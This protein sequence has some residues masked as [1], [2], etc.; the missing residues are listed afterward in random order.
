MSTSGKSKTLSLPWP[1]VA[2]TTR[3]GESSRSVL[4]YIAWIAREMR[5]MSFHGGSR[6]EE[7][8]RR[9]HQAYIAMFIPPIPGYGDPYPPDVPPAKHPGTWPDIPSA[10]VPGMTIRHQ[11]RVIEHL[12]VQLRDGDWMHARRGE[13]EAWDV[14]LARAREALDH[15]ELHPFPDEARTEPSEATRAAVEADQRAREEKAKRRAAQQRAEQRS[16]Q[17]AL[18]TKA[19]PAR[20]PTEPAKTAR[21]KAPSAANSAHPTARKATA[22]PPAKAA[23]KKVPT[24]KKAKAPTPKK[25]AKKAAKQTASRATK[26]STRPGKKSAKK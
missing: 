8:R 14:R 7:W 25:A 1:D 24:A 21:S 15:S 2:S 10:S 12:A 17:R 18:R 13:V 4:D 16:A 9:V 20:G 3:P 23:T 6:R 11:L 22:R 19:K 5:Q 26:S